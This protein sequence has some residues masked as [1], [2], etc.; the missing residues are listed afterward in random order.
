LRYDLALPRKR[1]TDQSAG[2]R[3]PPG[4]AASPFCAP[5]RRASANW[6][7]SNGEFD[8]GRHSMIKLL[9]MGTIELQPN[10]RSKEWQRDVACLLDGL[11]L[12]KK[13]RY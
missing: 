13:N 9:D 2:I 10:S 4:R 12:R 1:Q 7:R 3:E 6:F 5:H 8:K 11:R